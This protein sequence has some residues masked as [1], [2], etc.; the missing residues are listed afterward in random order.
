[1]PSSLRIPNPTCLHRPLGA[2][3]IAFRASRL[4]LSV[5]FLSMIQGFRER[6]TPTGASAGP[7][8]Y[9]GGPCI[10]PPPG[11][12]EQFKA[13]LR[14]PAFGDTFKDE[15][16]AREFVSGVRNGILH[17]AET[18]KWLIWRDEPSGRMVE[19]EQDGFALNR[20]L[21]YRA[22]KD[23]FDSYLQELRRPSTARCGR[24]SRRK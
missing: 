16:L 21:F 24:G 22:V 3:T 20:T 4:W 9:P 15:A 11:T 23:E 1:M 10:K 18:R 19:K 14:R 7:C 5:A 2:P 8:R 17:E 6:P 13:F 12:A